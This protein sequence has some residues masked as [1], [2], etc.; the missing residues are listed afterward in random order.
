[1]IVDSHVHVWNAETEETPWRAAWREFAPRPSLSVDVLLAEMDA[2]GVDRAAVI[3]PEWDLGGNELVLAAATS[4][5]DR[6]IAMPALSLRS[7]DAPGQLESWRSRPG[8][9]GLRQIFLKSPKYSPLMDGSA[10]WLWRAADDLGLR[11]MVWMP[12]QFQ[13]LGTVVAE[14]PNI[15]FAV[16]HLNLATRPSPTELDSVIEALAALAHHTN[17]AVKVSA[18]PTLVSDDYPYPA[19]HE[20]VRTLV[21]A[22]GP[23][24]VFWG[25]D[26]AR[27]PSG[28]PNAVRMMRQIGLSDSD[29]DQVMGGSFIHWANW[30]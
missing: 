7:P 1:M 15:R 18:L 2:A 26:F 16:D 9:G 14:Y 6:L 3:P 27:L 5:P 12:G 24:R 28:Y 4:H 17:L 30:L 21:R 20:S 29:Y 8:F 10:D 13:E 23:D 11:M 19:I 22:F 25:S